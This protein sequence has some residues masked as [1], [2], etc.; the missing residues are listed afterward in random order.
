MGTFFTDTIQQSPKYKSKKRVADLDLLEPET[1]R[2]VEAIVAD[3]K[4]HGL[5]L[6]VFE[7]FRSQ[8]RQTDLFNAGASK[9][10]SVGVH[11][12][13]LACD[14]TRSVGGEPSWSGDFN[15]L[16][17]LAHQHKMLWGGDWGN[18]NIPHAFVDSVHV[19]R[20]AL[21]RQAKLFRG[22]WYPDDGYDPY[23]ET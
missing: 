15:L 14:I 13:G 8:A 11:H 3:A 9:L 22:E 20:C 12:Y 19:Q 17:A 5:D 21:G 10:K 6:M 16:G 18:P 7:T 4:T 23:K 2:R 1:R